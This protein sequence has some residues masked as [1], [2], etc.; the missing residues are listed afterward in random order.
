MADSTLQL[1]IDTE[2]LREDLKADMVKSLETS[3]RMIVRD[4]LD[5]QLPRSYAEHK[6]KGHIL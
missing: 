4:E 2:E 1:R 3:V 5:K 6:A